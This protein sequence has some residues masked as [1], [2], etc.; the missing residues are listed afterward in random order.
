[1]HTELGQGN[2]EKLEVGVTELQERVEVP[3]HFG[4]TIP[5]VAQQAMSEN[6]QNFF[7]GFW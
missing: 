6:G 4:I 3:L 2:A 5:Q 1:M 7:E